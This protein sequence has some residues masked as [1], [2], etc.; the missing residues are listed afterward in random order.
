M[1]SSEF[2]D[3][4]VD[5]AELDAASVKQSLRKGAIAGL[6][7][8]AIAF[9][10]P[11]WQAVAFGFFNEDS[12]WHAVFEDVPWTRWALTGWGVAVPVLLLI[13]AW[14]IARRV[15]WWRAIIIYLTA[16]AMVTPL[17]ITAQ[18]LVA[19]LPQVQVVIWSALLVGR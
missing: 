13:G 3:I 5:E 2:D 1:T 11:I 19:R 15:T 6:I 8:A 4:E 16:W 14:L 7:A 17:I 18:T 9:A 12:G 10:Y